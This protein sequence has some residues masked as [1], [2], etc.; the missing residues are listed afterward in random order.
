MKA[1][2]RNELASV[3]QGHSVRFFFCCFFKICSYNNLL[4]QD[5]FETQKEEMFALLFI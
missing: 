3:K 1:E 5:T 4:L 2:D